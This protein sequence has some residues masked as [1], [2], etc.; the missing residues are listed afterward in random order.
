MI[1]VGI[2]TEA[3]KKTNGSLSESEPNYRNT[4]ENA[5]IGIY[6]IAF[7]GSK[8]RYVNTTVSQWLGYSKEEL[9]TMNPLDLLTDE[10]KGKFQ[11]IVI[12]SMKGEKTF[13]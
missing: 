9:L 13:S 5:P 7:D 1:L 6:E 2:N 12:E 8:L 3:G 11:E 4:V 10:S